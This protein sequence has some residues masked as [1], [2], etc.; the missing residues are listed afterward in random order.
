MGRKREMERKYERASERK[1]RQHEG[2]K[3]KDSARKGAEDALVR[4]PLPRW[5]ELAQLVP[6]HVLRDEHGD[7]VAPVVDL[8]PDPVVSPRLVS[9]LRAGH[10]EKTTEERK[11][12]DEQTHPTKLG[13]TVHE[14]AFVWMGTL[15]S[16][17]SRR[18]GKATKKG[19][20]RVFPD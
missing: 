18:F 2:G 15:F 17:A 1:T 10:T 3:A 12:K 4:E 19:P 14:R 9:P 20:V 6:D 16:N 11:Y 8:E 7:V 5:R 13:R